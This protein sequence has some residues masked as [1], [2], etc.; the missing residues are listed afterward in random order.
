MDYPSYC[1]VG[2]V[3][4]CRGLTEN[5]HSPQFVC[6]RIEV[7]ITVNLPVLLGV[8]WGFV[9]SMVHFLLL[10]HTI[11]RLLGTGTKPSSM[12]AQVSSLWRMLVVGSFLVAGLFWETVRVN[13]LVVVLAYAVSFLGV[14]M[15]YG[16]RLS[17]ETI[18]AEAL[19]K[20]SGR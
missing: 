4:S 19:H 17:M 16:I 5:V 14:I 1:L 7:L 15:V 11:R 12:A 9:A 8:M 18:R 6:S 13:G 2:M 3:L 10:R 20:E